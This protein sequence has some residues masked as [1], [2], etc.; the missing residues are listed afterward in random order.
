MTF[1]DLIEKLKRHPAPAICGCV[2]LVCF[3]NFYFR[4]DQISALQTRQEEIARQAEQVDNNLM[5]GS[6]LEEQL[7]AMRAKVEQLEAR[8]VRPS[9]LANNLKY[10]YRLESETGVTLSDLRQNPPPPP[11]K[12]AARP[13]FAG[14]AYNVVL[15]GSF[16]QVIAYFNDLENGERFYRLT[17]FNLQRGREA[18][19]ASLTLALNLELLGTP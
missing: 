19:Q 2:V 10:F 3:L 13:L 7:V 18:N 15:A 1:Q 12:G 9:E 17:N 6:N 16:N 4:M 11:A 5:T 8:L 14:V